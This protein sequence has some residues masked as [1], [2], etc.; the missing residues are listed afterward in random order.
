M[1]TCNIFIQSSFKFDVLSVGR[2]IN[3]DEEGGH[4]V[5]FARK[6]FTHFKYN[7][8]DLFRHI[9]HLNFESFV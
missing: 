7:K 3:L 2:L 8:Y 9:I 6:L 1:T 5:V 4:L